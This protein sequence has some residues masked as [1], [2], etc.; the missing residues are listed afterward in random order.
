MPTRKEVDMTVNISKKIVGFE[1]VKA[2]EQPPSSAEPQAAATESEVVSSDSANAVGDYDPMTEVLRGAPMGVYDAKRYGA[3]Y[4]HPVRGKQSLFVTASYFPAKGLIDGD[5][6]VADRWFEVFVPA[7]Q[8]EDI[9]PWVSVAMKLATL[10]L[11]SGVSL[12]RVLSRFDCPGSDNIPFPTIGGKKKFFTSE[13][14]VVGQ[15]FK[16]LAFQQGLIDEECHDIP[17]AK[18]AALAGSRVRAQAPSA[19][20]GNAGVAE[21]LTPAAGGDEY[22]SRATHCAKCGM[23]AVVILDG[24][25]TC[26][27]C[28]DTKCG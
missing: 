5:E 18:R 13:V 19:N 21:V 16:N 9:T 2:D 10:C 22:P 15:A 12:S 7:G 23:K 8:R 28:G 17:F 4:H 14:Q 1:V 25:A 27:N 26:L 3:E 11:Q 6:V 24:C 20:E